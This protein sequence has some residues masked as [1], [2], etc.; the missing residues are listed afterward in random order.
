MLSDIELNILRGFF[1]RPRQR[2]LPVIQR[3]ISYPVHEVYPALKTLQERGVVEEVWI[4]SG[5]AY[6]LLPEKEEAAEGYL[7][8][9][10]LRLH[11]FEKRYGAAAERVENFLRDSENAQE[12]DILL[13]CGSYA[14]GNAEEEDPVTIVRIAVLADQTGQDEPGDTEDVQNAPEESASLDGIK[15]VVMWTKEL[16]EMKKSDPETFRDIV[17]HCFPVKG[18]KLFYNLVYLAIGV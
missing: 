18:A 17:N 5:T 3:G 16:K 12:S 15:I 10:K 2:L 13:V 7:F 1:P 14:R 6:T 9:A 8:Y 11:E 4:R